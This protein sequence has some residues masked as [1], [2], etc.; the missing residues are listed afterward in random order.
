MA[1]NKEEDDTHSRI[2]FQTINNNKTDKIALNMMVTCYL[3]LC[4]NLIGNEFFFIV[5]FYPR[6]YCIEHVNVSVSVLLLLSR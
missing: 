1:I 2:G 6:C 5:V 3:I 4:C